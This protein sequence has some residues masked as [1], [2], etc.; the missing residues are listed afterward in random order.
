VKPR[1]PNPAAATGHTL[2]HKL[3]QAA[4]FIGKVRSGQSSEQALASSPATLMAPTR[5]LGFLALRNLGLCGFLLSQL[6][7]RKPSPEAE[8][9]LTVALAVLLAPDTEE[10]AHGVYAE[11]T[12]VNQAIV[13]A[14]AHPKTAHASG[15]INA[16][17]RRFLRER[18]A[19]LDRAQQDETARWN[20]PPWWSRKILRDHPQQ[21]ALI[22]ADLHRRAPMVLRV[23]PNAKM[24]D[25]L[26]G[27]SPLH[28]HGQALGARRVGEF[29]WALNTPVAVTDIDEFRDG[30]VTVQDAAAQ[31]A[32]PMLLRALNADTPPLSQPWRVLDACAAP[33]GKTTHLIEFAQHLGR[34]IEVT[35]LDIDSQRC[36][37]IHENLQRCGLQAHVLSADAGHPQQWWDGQPFDAILL[38]APCSASGI[39]RRHPDIPWLRREGDIAQLAQIQSRLL[40]A[41]WPLLKPG[42]LMLYC[43]C[44]QFRAEGSDQIE[45]FLSRNTQALL[46]PSP[47]HLLAGFDTSETVLPE[48][49]ETGIRHPWSPLPSATSIREHDGFFYALLQNNVPR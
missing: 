43:T 23:R 12:I 37:R 45:A 47:G 2:A 6:A 16:C 18:D 49:P 7:D 39:V 44:S 42:G 13:A 36:A 17:L 11:F 20:C 3:A 40:D 14:K 41:L 24:T 34:A 33:G 48:N 27:P 19:L 8:N 32:A 5:A 28:H 30:S 9:L 29:A 38:D 31:L 21:G 26:A 15:F 25:G 10:D 46:L 22:L 1:N 35:A 4:L